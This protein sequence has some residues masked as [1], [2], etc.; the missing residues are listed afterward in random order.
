M[1]YYFN[2]ATITKFYGFIRKVNFES[3]SNEDIVRIDALVEKWRYYFWHD[4]AGLLTAMTF[5]AEKMITSKKGFGVES[6]EEKAYFYIKMLDPDFLFLEA[7]ETANKLS[8]TKELCNL[9]F[10]V[11]DP[12]IIYLE[13]LI[14]KKFFPNELFWAKERIKTK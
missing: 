3:F 12:M 5:V 13:T 10:H 1:K 8:E 4:S 6:W 7:H 9:N 11:Y 2:K 14:Y